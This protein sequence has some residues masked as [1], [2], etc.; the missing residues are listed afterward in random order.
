MIPEVSDK[1]SALHCAKPDTTLL[2]H[3]S[4]SLASL[5]YTCWCDAGKPQAHISAVMNTAPSFKGF[6]LTQNYPNP[7]NPNTIINYIVPVES[8]VVIK[9]FD[10][11]GREMSVL[12]NANKQPGKYSYIFEMNKTHMASG[13]YFY[14][15]ICKYGAESYSSVKKMIVLK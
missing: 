3:A 2:R 8:N 1:W 5:I 6:E 11:T 10:A 4:L 12:V 14:Q 15:M 13:I 7:F 9:L